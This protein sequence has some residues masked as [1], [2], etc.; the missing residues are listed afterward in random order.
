MLRFL[1]AGRVAGELGLGGHDGTGGLFGA[2]R[3]IIFV[4]FFGL[5]SDP[6]RGKRGV[7]IV[8]IKLVAAATL[9]GVQD[10]RDH[11][12]R[13]DFLENTPC[14]RHGTSL[15][16][17]GCGLGHG[18]QKKYRP[19]QITGLR[20]DDVWAHLPDRWQI[21]EAAAGCSKRGG[22]IGI[23]RA[24]GRVSPIAIGRQRGGRTDEEW[25][26]QDGLICVK[27]LTSGLW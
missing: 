10:K 7:V 25:R 14:R 3:Q 16:I 12:G 5:Q 13:T 11:A 22:G 23:F 18:V 9:P 27:V 6:F 4:E 21:F 15:S 17:Q 24:T 19:G 20:H 1:R 8:V 26:R 2:R